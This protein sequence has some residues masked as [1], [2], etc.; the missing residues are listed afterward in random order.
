[1]LEKIEKLKVREEM[2]AP[3]FR[4]FGDISERV[5]ES[6]QLYGGNPELVPRVL[7]YIFPEDIDFSH[8]NPRQ[9]FHLLKDVNTKL[10]GMNLSKFGNEDTTNTIKSTL[11]MAYRTSHPLAFNRLGQEMIK[12]LKEKKHSHNYLSLP[13]IEIGYGPGTISMAFY[14]IAQQMGLKPILTGLDSSAVHQAIAK[15]L[16]PEN[17]YQ[18]KWESGD[19]TKYDYLNSRNDFR[20]ASAFDVGHHLNEEQYKKLVKN[21]INYS[22]EDVLLTDPTNH[23]LAQ[24]IVGKITDKD[25]VHQEAVDSYNAAYSRH[26]LIKMYESVVNNG[27]CDEIA[28]I[29]IVD[30]GFVNIIHIRQK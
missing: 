25:S 8:S 19:G 26:N 7:K 14:T 12:V 24:K 9:V 28:N 2:P 16:Y 11:S 21:L 23:K 29:N 22:S 5:P 18:V 10:R 20:I 3:I 4:M 30:T 17:H 6:P 27:H 1:M 15:H 13:I